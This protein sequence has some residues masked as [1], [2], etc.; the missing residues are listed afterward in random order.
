VIASTR[1][2][3]MKFSKVRENFSMLYQS[4]ADGVAVGLAFMYSSLILGVQSAVAAL[5]MMPMN[6]MR[7]VNKMA[8][9]AIVFVLFSSQIF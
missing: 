2:T 1:T 4:D 7:T 6:M 5:S 3:T 9:C 8:I